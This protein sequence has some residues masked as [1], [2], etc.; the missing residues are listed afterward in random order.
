MDIREL[1]PRTASDGDLLEMHAIEQAC[2][3]D[4]EPPT[5][6]DERLA[7][8]RFP[9]ATDERHHWLTDG[10]FASLYI[11]GPAATFLQLCVRPDRRRVGIGS[12]LL[13][14]AVAR[15]RDRG[16]EAIR[17]DH[18][19]DAGAAFAR[20]AGAIDGQRVV[21]SLV[22]LSE[23]ELPEPFVPEGWRL[24]TWLTRV[25]DEHL[26]A[27]VRARGAMDDAPADDN[28]EFPTATAERV[29][30][31]E[32]SLVERERE[33][34]LTVALDDEGTIG[35]FTE[36][37][38]SRG[39]TRGFTDD[40]GTVAEHRGK[41]LARAVKLESLRVMRADH[42]EV[43]IVTTS[44]AEENAVMRHINESVGFH[45]VVTT[46]TATLTL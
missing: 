33:M 30:A 45:P 19:S 11:H 29:R 32:R 2:L 39:S 38:L 40:T 16:V 6:A 41:G 21:F 43:E 23:V 22:R 18:A 44:N 26:E 46:T 3:V 20:H 7:F 42:P 10:G 35:A 13:A 12:A 24:A 14:A 34:R 15:G 27:F 31:S 25:P 36:L 4:G 17:G 37:R 28:F 5:A 9:P 8:W 1:D